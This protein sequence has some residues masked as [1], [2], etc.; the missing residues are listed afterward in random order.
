MRAN[1]CHAELQQGLQINKQ[2]PRRQCTMQACNGAGCCSGAD[3]CIWQCQGQCGAART[4]HRRNWAHAAP[5]AFD[6]LL[7]YHAT[8]L[9][10]FALLHTSIRQLTRRSQTY[11]QW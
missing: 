7:C 8:S 5:Y 2:M 3:R 1:T 9:R 6:S 11:L 4:L 10:L